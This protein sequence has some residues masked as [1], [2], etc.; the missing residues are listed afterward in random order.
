MC[1]CVCKGMFYICKYVLNEDFACFRLRQSWKI[2]HFPLDLLGRIDQGIAAHGQG[3]ALEAGVRGPPLTRDREARDRDREFRD[4]EASDRDRDRDR[5]R[6][7]RDREFRDREVRDREVRDREVRDREARDREAR[8]REVRDREARDRE[9]RDREARDREA[10]DRE[11]RDRDWQGRLHPMPF[12][13]DGRLQVPG[14]TDVP[15]SPPRRDISSRPKY[16]E[17][18]PS[19]EELLRV[20]RGVGTK[21]LL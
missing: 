7:F 6:E 8:D 13:N 16:R 20:E 11:A 3:H 14:Y 21:L 18:I 9:A 4:R 5:D 19:E 1:V 15:R 10:R 12:R 17:P 2:E